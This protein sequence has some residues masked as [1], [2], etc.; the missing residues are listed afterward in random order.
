[1]FKLFSVALVLALT[2]SLLP[3]QQ[4]TVQAVSPDVVI[5]QVYG[6]GGNIGAPYHNDYVELFNRGNTSVDLT[7]WSIQYA[8]VNGNSWGVTTLAGSIPPASYYLVQESPGAG[9]GADIPTPDATGTLAMSAVAGKIVLAN[10]SI[11]LTGSCPSDASIVDRVGYGG[12]DCPEA[13][14]IAAL[15][16][17]TAAFRNSGG[18]DDTNDN[19]ADFTVAAPAPRNSSSPYHYCSEWLGVADATPMEFGLGPV[20]PNPSRGALRFELALP[21]ATPVR[22]T[23]LDVQGREVATLAEGVFAPGRHPIEWNG[24]EAPGTARSGVYFIRLAVPGRSWMRRV[25]LMN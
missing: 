16:N 9:G 1:L 21:R 19:S 18:C 3:L 22:V 10:D 14:S 25:V 8:S 5:S 6:G 4:K 13:A 2:I 23:M 20:I 15:D 12:A 7:G 11:M 24:L 17:V